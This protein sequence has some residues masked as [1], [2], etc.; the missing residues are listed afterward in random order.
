MKCGKLFNKLFCKKK[1]KIFPNETNFYSSHNKSM[2]TLSC[3]SNESSWTLTVKH[4]TYIKDNVI[5][6]FAKFHLY[7]NFVV[8]E[9]TSFLIFY[10]KFTLYV[11]QAINQI[12]R[13]GQ[14]SHET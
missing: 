8:F 14:R 6:M 2:E 12:K 1:K 3:H 7:P 9:E 5:S 11:A 13:F 10:Q 4:K